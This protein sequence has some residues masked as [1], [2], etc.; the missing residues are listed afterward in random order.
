MSAQF[1]IHGSGATPKFHDGKS[2]CETCRFAHVMRGY[3]H[4]EVRM[5]CGAW[6]SN[7]D[8]NPHYNP[9][10]NRVPFP[11]AECSGYMDKSAMSLAEMQG[12]A[13]TVEPDRVRVGG[14]APTKK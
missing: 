2:L 8:N 9:G 7:F 1:K 4:N 6:A 5:I 3:S 11:V 14:F 12:I 10:L 13:L